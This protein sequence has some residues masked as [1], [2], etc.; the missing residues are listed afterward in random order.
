M[1]PQ[2]ANTPL[3]QTMSK[4]IGDIVV[5]STKISTKKKKLFQ[6]DKAGLYPPVQGMTEEEMLRSDPVVFA[7]REQNL[8]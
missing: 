6:Y 5:P 8:A 1:T 2:K 3:R 4:E 7:S